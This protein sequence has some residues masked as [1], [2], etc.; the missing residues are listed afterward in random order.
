[1]NNKI[2]LSTLAL[3]SLFTACDDEYMDQFDINN[4]VTDVKAL[5]IQLEKSDYSAIASNAANQSKA[6][7]LDP[8]GNTY[9]DALK[10]VGEQGYFTEM[11]PAED[12]IP[13]WLDKKY[14]NADEGSTFTVTYAKEREASKYMNDFASISSYQLTQED[15]EAVWGN[16]V[17]ASFLSPQTKSKISDIL[18]EKSN[19]AVAGNLTVVNYAYSDVEP[20]IGGGNT[21]AEPTWTP[22]AQVAR[23]AG[24]NWYFVNSGPIDLSAY[25]GM[26]VNIGFQYT[27]SETAYATWEFQNLRVGNVPYVNLILFSQQADGSFKKINRSS[28]FK[29]A[30]NYV[31]AALWADGKYY[32]FGRIAG[33]KAYGYCT[34]G[35]ITVDNGVIAS[36]DAADYVVTLEAGANGG[37]FIK[38]VLGKYFYTGKNSSGKYYNSFNVADTTGE[39]GYEWS[40]TNINKDNDL[41]VIKNIDA[42]NYLRFTIYNGTLEFGNWPEATVENNVFAS[43]LISDEAGFSVNGD[44]IWTNN[45]YGWVAKGAS[46]VANTSMLVSPAIEIGENA[47]LPFLTFDEAWRYGTVDQLTVLVSTDYSAASAKSLNSTNAI[48]RAS[49]DVRPTS[50]ALYQYDGSAWKEYSNS[51]FQLVVLNDAE[52]AQLTQTSLA[53]VKATLPI[54]L[55][56]KLPYFVSETTAVVVYKDG[57]NYKA[58]E[59]EVKDGV[60]SEIGTYTTETTTFTKEADGISANMSS[61]YDN[62]LLGDEGGFT[63]Y[64]V[65]KGEGL[66]YVWANTAQYGWKASAYVNKTNIPSESWLV[67]PVVNLKKAKQPVLVFDEVYQYTNGA[68]PTDFLKVRVSSDFNGDVKT[69]SWSELTIPTWSTGADWNFV[70]TGYIDLSSLCGQSI[71]IAFVY[72]SNDTTGP[73]WEIKNV[74][75]IEMPA[76]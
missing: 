56:N 34:P 46:G 7:A 23:S 67:S 11:I 13:A 71:V 27:S 8:E 6:L 73:T 59:F 21:P 19:G 64:D 32:P 28:E 43:T 41:F 69:A 45:N 15:Y 24:S 49:A 66:N 20:S 65:V 33:D 3:A 60:W 10:K 37:F 72:T 40:I 62:T 2:I 38:N 47:V 74:K 9:V 48:T 35:A 31:I 50:S 12:F 26:T 14:F 22:I 53:N 55:A 52:N 4:P 1:M 16:K 68:A 75:V 18:A 44:A 58:A 76:E 39:D 25:K 70:N 57:K 30:G 54:M 42:A 17:K 36:A 5:S 61:F 63:A 29:G 51:D